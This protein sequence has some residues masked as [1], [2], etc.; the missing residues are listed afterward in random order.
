[1]WE[2]RE[3]LRQLKL[4]VEPSDNS[5]NYS[6]LCSIGDAE[7]EKNRLKLNSGSSDFTLGFYRN[8]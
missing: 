8:N 1:M 2:N 5:G 6:V 4:N 3:S 7:R